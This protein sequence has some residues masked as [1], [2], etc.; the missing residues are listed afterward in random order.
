MKVAEIKKSFQILRLRSVTVVVR[1][2]V[3]RL[4]MLRIL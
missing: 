1:G 4:R 2:S 3:Q